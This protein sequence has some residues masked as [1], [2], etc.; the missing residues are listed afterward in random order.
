MILIGWVCIVLY[1]VE[2]GLF[3]LFMMLWSI[4]WFVMVG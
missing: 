4:F 1:S 3:D 2:I